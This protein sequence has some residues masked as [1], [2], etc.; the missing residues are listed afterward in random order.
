MKKDL[1][2]K[3]FATFLLCLVIIVTG[4]RIGP[5]S[6]RQAK[7]ERTE[8]LSAPME[9]LEA[10]DVDTAF[11]S[12]KIVGGD[13][14]NCRIKAKICAQALNA[15]EAK[16]L[17]EK[18]KIKLEPV[19]KTLNIIVDKP[20]VRNN[21]CIGVSFDIVVPKKTAIECSTSYG[22]IKLTDIQANVK[23]HT[24]FASIK[25]ENIEG[26]VELETAYGQ[27]ECRNITSADINARSSFGNIDIACSPKSM[28]EISAD[29]ATAYGSIEF[30][31]PPGFSGRV[32]LETSF[33]SIRTDLPITV[34]GRISKD[35]IK[36]SVGQGSGKLRLKTSFGSIRIR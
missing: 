36:G 11:G 6:W 20:K 32:D 28:P 2:A 8:Q 26:S 31:T 13:V 3:A 12:I 34:K 10:V 1:F 21:R 25:C 5:G 29:I 33:G 19:D 15:E 30:T 22:S 9:N 23:A 7:Y 18:V 35:R 17:A 16:Q 24:S 4:C 27:V 14:T